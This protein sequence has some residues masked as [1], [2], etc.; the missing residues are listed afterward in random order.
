MAKR[1]RSD[2]LERLIEQV[3]DELCNEYDRKQSTIALWEVLWLSQSFALIT[4]LHYAYRDTH[5][6]VVPKDGFSPNVR[7]H[8]IVVEWCK[9]HFIELFN[10]SNLVSR[11][12]RS[13]IWKAQSTTFRSYAN[14]TV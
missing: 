12:E 8:N 1:R 2:Y 7:I 11:L 6:L 3:I 13:C 14:Q 9:T 4:T 5:I 10:S